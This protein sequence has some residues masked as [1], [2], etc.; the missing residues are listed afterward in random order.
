ALERRWG[1]P[2]PE[3][4]GWMAEVL[5]QA[6]EHLIRIPL[7]PDLVRRY[8]ATVRFRCA[9]VESDLDSLPALCTDAALQFGLDSLP[10]PAHLLRGGGGVTD[11]PAELRDAELLLT[12]A[13]HAT[14]LLARAE[15]LDKPLVVGR[16]DPEAIAAIER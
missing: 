5:T 13:F 12:T 9:C 2:A 15:A 1:A 16:V 8:T 14:S 3:T 10:V 7:L 11:L 4:A 6:S